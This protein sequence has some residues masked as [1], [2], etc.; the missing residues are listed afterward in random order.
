MADI[1]DRGNDRA[2]EILEDAL[3]DRE[4]GRQLRDSDYCED[5]GDEIPYERR[6]FS[7]YIT[8]CIHCQ[9]RHDLLVRQGRA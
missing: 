1:I 9:E 4:I 8:R 2:Q 7:P 6:A 3:R 5:C